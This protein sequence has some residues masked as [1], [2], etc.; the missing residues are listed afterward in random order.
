MKIYQQPDAKEPERFWKKY[1]NQKKKHN[2]KAEWIN[3]MTKELQRLE[4]GPNGEI[5]I[6]LLKTT[7]EK[8]HTGKRKAIKKCTISC[9]RNSPSFTR[10]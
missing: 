4:G 6:G 10:D 1:G 9:S 8:Y 2:G 3:N 7:I 5:H